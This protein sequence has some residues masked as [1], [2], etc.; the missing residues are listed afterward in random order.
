MRKQ[1]NS[2]PFAGSHHPL[3]GS[4]YVRS[5]IICSQVH[6]KNKNAHIRTIRILLAVASTHIP[7][8]I[9][10]IA[11][12][13]ATNSTDRQVASTTVRSSLEQKNNLTAKQQ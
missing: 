13:T 8:T 7:G 2:R 11:D 6:V 12:T 1:I 4:T 5:I 10:K 3:T 9:V